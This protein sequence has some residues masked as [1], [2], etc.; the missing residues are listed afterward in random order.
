MIV[1]RA[2]FVP[3]RG[4]DERMSEM[5]HIHKMCW[6]CGMRFKSSKETF[7]HI[8]NYEDKKDTKLNHVVSKIGDE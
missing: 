7:E 8:E 1:I 4:R 5:I 3:L 6:K 2:L